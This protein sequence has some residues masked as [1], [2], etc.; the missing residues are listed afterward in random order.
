MSIVINVQVVPFGIVIL[1]VG[2][3]TIQLEKSALADS[4]AE[5]HYQE[6]VETASTVYEFLYEQQR[7][8]YVAPPFTS[9]F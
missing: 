5:I 9:S 1:Q 4:S 6:P 3:P 7:N 8:I 2:S